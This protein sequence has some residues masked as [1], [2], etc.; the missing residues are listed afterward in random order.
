M[1]EDA[2][3]S[4]KTTAKLAEATGEAEEFLLKDRPHIASNQGGVHTPETAA[5]ST[6]SET[7]ADVTF[8]GE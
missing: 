6:V 5:V 3:Q 4:G 8:P 2:I 1:T 7:N